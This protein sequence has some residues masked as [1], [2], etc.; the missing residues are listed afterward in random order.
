MTPGGTKVAQ[1]A[2]EAPKKNAPEGASI[3]VG[4]LKGLEPSTTRITIWD[5]TN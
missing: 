2:P 4:W 1:R 5:S 3:E